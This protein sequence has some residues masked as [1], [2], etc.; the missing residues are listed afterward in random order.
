MATAQDQSDKPLCEVC[1]DRE[2]DVVCWSH[3][4]D[5][6]FEYCPGCAPKMMA[7]FPDLVVI[8]Q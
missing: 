6:K 1:E 7:K 5:E 4:L 2:A 3:D 8:D